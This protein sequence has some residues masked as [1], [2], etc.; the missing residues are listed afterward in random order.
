MVPLWQA[1][2]LQAESDLADGTGIGSLQKCAC[3]ST[4]GQCA[5]A[6]LLVF[7][8]ATVG[9]LRSSPSVQVA[10]K[11]P[12]PPDRLYPAGNVIWYPSECEYYLLL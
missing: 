1:N 10:W 2:Q 8:D 5:F 6:R 3:S 7:P 9:S 11:I 4:S 12:P